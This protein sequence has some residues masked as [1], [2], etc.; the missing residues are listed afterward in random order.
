MELLKH[1]FVNGDLDSKPL[2]DLLLEYRAEVVEEEVLD[3][4]SEVSSIKSFV[5][6]LSSL[7]PSSVYQVGF[8]ST[9]IGLYFDF[10]CVATPIKLLQPKY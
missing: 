1:E 6:S 3:D 10:S 8:K 4:D 7:I 9:K 2:R 5:F